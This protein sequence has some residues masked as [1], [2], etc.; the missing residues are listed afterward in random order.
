MIA[1]I[2]IFKVNY[3]HINDISNGK[4][5]ESEIKDNSN[6]SFKTKSL[7]TTNSNIYNSD[8]SRK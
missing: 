1:I 6:N 3:N 5:V 7:T 8:K 4:V 2:S